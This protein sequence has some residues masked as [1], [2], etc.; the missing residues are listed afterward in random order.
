M[1][2]SDVLAANQMYKDKFKLEPGL[3]N[4]I[5]STKALPWST[6]MIWGIISDNLALFGN[7]RKSYIIIMSL[8]SSLSMTAAF[9]YRGDNW[10]VVFALLFMQ[11][12]AQ[13]FTNVVVNAILIVQAKKHLIDGA[14][15]LQGW[16][17]SCLA[18]GGIL[19]ATT[20]G[21]ITEF[22]DG[23]YCFILPAVSSIALM[24]LTFMMDSS[25]ELEQGEK[26]PETVRNSC[27]ST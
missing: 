11:S 7:R 22:S 9:F 12:F 24:I 19:G 2:V 18:L 5:H 3:L 13:A 8:I 1:R 10:K 14:A 21:F 17:H 4:T 15:D 23:Q 6:K 27:C 26:Y 20:A 25:F 16:A